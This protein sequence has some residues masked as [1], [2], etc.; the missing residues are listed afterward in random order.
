MSL[1]IRICTGI[2]EISAILCDC[3]IIKSYEGKMEISF[4]SNGDLV[5][6]IF[7][8]FYVKMSTISFSFIAKY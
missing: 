1:R 7:K 2:K 6:P 3:Q 8:F 4:S 5:V